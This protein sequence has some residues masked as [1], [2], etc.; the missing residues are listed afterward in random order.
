MCNETSFVGIGYCH[1]YLLPQTSSYHVLFICCIKILPQQKMWHQVH[2]AMG[3]NVATYQI[4][5]A[6][7]H[8]I[9]TINFLWR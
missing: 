2:T 7:T 8:F 6:I 1:K 4:T 9:A 3:K 5:V